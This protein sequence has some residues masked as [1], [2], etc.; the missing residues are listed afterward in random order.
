MRERDESGSDPLEPSL[1]EIL[2]LVPGEPLR[3]RL[4]ARRVLIAERRPAEEPRVPP[5]RDLVLAVDVRGFPLPEV[6]GWLH[7]AGKSGLLHFAHDDHAKWVWLHR[8]EVVFAASNQRIDRLGHSLLRAGAI[9]LDEMR[10]AERSYRTGQRFGKILV[11]RGLLSPRELWLG[12]Q[13]QVEEIVRSL[14]SYPSGWVC[15]WDGELQPDNVVRLS[16]SSRQLVQGGLRWRD[17]LRRFVAALAD[18][19]VR[20]EAVAPRRESLAGTER[21]LF[22]ALGQESAF[23]PLCRRV[24]LDP[25]TCA[26]TLQLLHRAGAVRIRRTE[27]D[28]DTTQRVPR[29]DPGE[30]LRVHIQEAVK[31]L[32]ELAAAVDAVAAGDGLR[33]RFAGAIEEVAGRFP[34]LLAGVRPGRGAALDPELLI[35]RALALPPGRHGDVREALAA[36]ADY[37]EFEVKNH[38]AIADPDAVLRSVEPLRAKLHA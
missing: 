38:P 19:R 6:F 35:E 31:L 37:L 13:R 14:F 26:R 30:R 1:G 7:R 36:L 8:G 32:G 4:A 9:S 25:P 28:P 27:D 10:D 33:E 29:N 22:E 23:G 21:L 20:I 18:T 11:E 16:L 34:G 24:G 2:G 15:F 17:E 12:L 5:D 3:V